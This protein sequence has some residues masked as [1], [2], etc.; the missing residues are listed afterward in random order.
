MTLEDTSEYV[1]LK[2]ADIPSIINPQRKRLMIRKSIRQYSAL[3]DARN[4]RAGILTEREMEKRQSDRECR[5][6]VQKG[7]RDSL[8]QAYFEWETM[9]WETFLEHWI[10]MLRYW[11]NEN[12]DE[13]RTRAFRAYQRHR[14]AQLRDQYRER[15]RQKKIAMLDG[16]RKKDLAEKAR[17]L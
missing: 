6:I 9:P 3:K 8:D 4:V 1:P 11:Q 12:E 17:S 13:E 2:E 10:V 15:M 5:E 7:A 14:D 16:K